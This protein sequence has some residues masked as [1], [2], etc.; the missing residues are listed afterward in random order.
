MKRSKPARSE[1]R[2][3]DAEQ[4]EEQE[5]RLT[6]LFE[7]TKGWFHEAFSPLDNQLAKRFRVRGLFFY[8]PT[9]AA[10]A[11]GQCEPFKNAYNIIINPKGM[12]KLG[13][14][15]LRALLVHELLH[16]IVF[17]C[18]DKKIEL[19]DKD[20]CLD[21]A[22]YDDESSGSPYWVEAAGISGTRMG[23]EIAQNT[24]EFEHLLVELAT[25]ELIQEHEPESLQS[26]NDLVG[27]TCDVYAVP[28]WVK[29]HFRSIPA[30][31]LDLLEAAFDELHLVLKRRLKKLRQSFEQQAKQK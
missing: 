25:L 21:H 15:K 29:G 28:H 27:G 11:Y 13:Q 24:G 18:R 7:E 30:N 6:A 22:R 19:K 2:S 16:A 26:A 5:K 23:L 3:T 9:G 31:Q 12:E 8:P 17:G 10:D 14:P 4:H 1:R 20:C